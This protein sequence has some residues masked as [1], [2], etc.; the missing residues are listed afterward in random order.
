VTLA[1]GYHILLPAQVAEL[2]KS[3]LATTLFSSNFFF[4]S[5]TGYFDGPA[6]LKPLLH[7][8]SLAVEEQFYILF[9]IILFTAL[10]F[11]RNRTTLSIVLIIIG[12]FMLR[13]LGLKFQPSMTF[14]M[15]PTRAWELA[16]GALLAVGGVEHAALLK[17]TATRHALSLLGLALIVFGFLWL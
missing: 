6:E 4:F 3:A 12:S 13:V 17:K 7:T 15:L 2:G 9:P 16:L 1:I 10:K 14:Y 8:W 5:Q 11:F